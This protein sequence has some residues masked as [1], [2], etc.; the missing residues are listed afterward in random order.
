MVKT[1]YLD[2]H[3]DVI[4]NLISGLSDAIDL[5][6]SDPAK[7]QAEVND[8]LKALTGKPLKPDVHRRRRSNRSASRS[9]RSNLRCRR[10]PITPRHLGFL[11]SSDLGQIFDLT[12]L[13]QVLQAEGKPAISS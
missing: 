9:T 10:T 12:L 6:K 8:G 13:N 7:A 3:D 4:K 2:A 11:K 1:D 5:I